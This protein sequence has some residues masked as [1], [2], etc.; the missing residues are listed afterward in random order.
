M[1]H[2]TTKDQREFIIRQP[3]EDD[4]EAILLYSKLIFASTDQVLT[5]PQDFNMTVED[6]RGWIKML[7]TTPNANILAAELN[8]EV[9]GL[10]FF[11]P[12]MRIKNAHTGEFGITVHPEFQQSGI[13][14]QLIENLL[15]WAKENS[16]LEKVYLQVFATNHP[17]IKLY[18]S[19]G[20]KEEGRLIK[21]IRQLSGEYVDVLQMYIE[22]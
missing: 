1:I 14:R 16:Q 22:V 9:V 21:A 3:T 15:K 8:G 12:N 2:C 11:V 4:A 17:A 20:F 19:L 6:E 13:G 5:T 10:L 7:T 18:S